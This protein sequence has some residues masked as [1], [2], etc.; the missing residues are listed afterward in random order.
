MK[1]LAGV[2]FVVGCLASI[3]GCSTSKQGYVAK[4]NQMFDAGKYADA[5]I[6]YG[7]AIQKDRSYGEAY[8][9]LG[10]AEIKEQKPREAFDALYRAFSCCQRTS[11]SKSS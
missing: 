5:A 3:S 6:N 11:M 1:K 4:G 2:L 9:H 7:K 8:Y 10:L